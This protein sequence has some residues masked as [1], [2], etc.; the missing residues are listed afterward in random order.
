MINSIQK[1][2]IHEDSKNPPLQSD[3]D[4]KLTPAK[5]KGNR[6]KLDFTSSSSP[7]ARTTG[8]DADCAHLHSSM[9][10]TPPVIFMR[11]PYRHS[12]MTLLRRV[13]THPVDMTGM[14]RNS[15]DPVVAYASFQSHWC[16]TINMPVLTIVGACNTNISPPIFRRRTYEYGSIMVMAT[17]S[18]QQDIMEFHIPLIQMQHDAA[19]RVV[20]ETTTAYDVGDHLT[21]FVLHPQDHR[22][23]LALI[24]LWNL[25]RYGCMDLHH[26][27]VYRPPR[28]KVTDELH[29]LGLSGE[30]DTTFQIA[31]PSIFS[32]VMMM[33]EEL[34]L[35]AIGYRAKKKAKPH[36]DG[37][38]GVTAPSDRSDSMM[39]ARQMPQTATYRHQAVSTIVIVPERK[40][41]FRGRAHR[42]PYF[43]PPAI[44]HKQGYP[45]G[46]IQPVLFPAGFQ[47]AMN[48]AISPLV[49]VRSIVQELA[50]V[51]DRCSVQAIAQIA[52]F[53]EVSKDSM[54]DYMDFT[55]EKFCSMV[56]P[57]QGPANF[58]FVV[59]PLITDV[60][61][62]EWV[63][64][65]KHPAVMMDHTQ[66]H[67]VKEG[68]DFDPFAY[69]DGCRKQT[70]LSCTEMV[71]VRPTPKQILDSKLWFP[72]APK[73]NP[74]NGS[75]STM[76]FLEKEVEDNFERVIANLMP[77]QISPER[78]NSQLEWFDFTKV[79]PPGY[80]AVPVH[81]SG[82][83]M[84]MTEEEGRKLQVEEETINDIIAA[85]Q[86]IIDSIENILF[87][88][89]HPL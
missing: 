66:V 45:F 42:K 9:K 39:M 14:S 63:H 57:N 43:Y 29:I 31:F 38:D 19:S 48:I 83:T 88:N 2:H 50:M 1:T 17:T 33:L 62:P 81:P 65:T 11:F 53:F 10:A 13:E 74:S 23:P 60:M 54:E 40:V 86:D 15:M 12:L 37:N 21:S 18:N 61:P 56:V 78:A 30:R 20:L 59:R 22:K 69:S 67:F 6:C 3:V 35:Q 64:S 58:P 4:Q 16:P 75:E 89:G 44:R 80:P 8:P 68:I 32:P 72:D 73:N 46:T 85:D 77:D 55:F 87:T 28:P 70:F 27:A 49:T 24:K 7:I 26:Q 25:S 41:Y 51:N 52:D 47:A 71:G 84:A 82:T 36:F 79:P 34:D 5:I 76:S